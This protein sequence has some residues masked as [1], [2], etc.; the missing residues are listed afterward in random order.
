MAAITE[1][2]RDPTV[3]LTESAV[4]RWALISVSVAFLV[5]FL[6]LPLAIVL[7]EAFRQGVTGW[8]EAIIAPDT[9]AAVFLTLLVAVV[10]VPL[11]V[12]F[13]VAAAWCV[14]KCRFGAVKTQ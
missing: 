3:H 11:N 10:A 6:V 13:G 14:A 1:A 12:V 7:V 5:L 2:S 9:R 4:A 8:I